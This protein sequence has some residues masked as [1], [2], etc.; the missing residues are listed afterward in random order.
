MK[1][2]SVINYEEFIQL[3]KSQ[4]WKSD[5]IKELREKTFTVSTCRFHHNDIY[6]ML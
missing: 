1:C 5:N 6:D 4:V 2:V 3:L